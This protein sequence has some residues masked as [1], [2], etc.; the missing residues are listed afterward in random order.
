MAVRT[1]R[2]SVDLRVEATRSYLL[3]SNR[4]R[5]HSEIVRTGNNPR[6]STTGNVFNRLGRGANMREMLNRNREQEHFQHSTIE[7][8]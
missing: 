2:T 3:E 1:Q 6:R 8:R 5:E 4:T 7:R